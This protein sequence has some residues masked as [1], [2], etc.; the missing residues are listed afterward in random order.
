MIKLLNIRYLLNIYIYKEKYLFYLYIHIIPL[1]SYV[2]SNFS[3]S[4]S[5]S[6]TFLE[7]IKL[8]KI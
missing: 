6:N 4:V 2:E 7:E 8:I 5:L 1:F 3:L